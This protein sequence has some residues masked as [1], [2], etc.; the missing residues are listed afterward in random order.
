MLI[1]IN[2]KDKE[3]FKSMEKTKRDNEK[4]HNPIRRDIQ[5]WSGVFGQFYKQECLHCK[6]RLYYHQLKVVII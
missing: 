3:L 1:K 4:I 5:F 6:K 2:A